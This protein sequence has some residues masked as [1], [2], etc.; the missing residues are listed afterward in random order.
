MRHRAWLCGMLAVT[1]LFGGC[2]E[3]ENQSEH[4][5]QDEVIGTTAIA[6]TI[7]S[8]EIGAEE[9]VGGATVTLNGVYS[10][11][12]EHVRNGYESDIIFFSFTVANHTDAPIAANFMQTCEM[13]IDG[14]ESEAFTIQARSCL[15]QQFGN[16]VESF[17]E[18]IP[19]G[20]T[21]TG[22]I[23]AEMYRGYEEATLLYTPL[24]GASGDNKDRSQLISYTF[25]P[26][27]LEYIGDPVYMVTTST[28]ETTDET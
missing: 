25:H 27:E 16:D 18:E 7:L 21:V 8:G 23:G 20:E 15:Y 9:T 10:S 17:T 13:V 1:M 2:A 3:E 5:V 4:V 6:T 11:S 14:T 28:D 22:Y 19:A 26:D 24:A 12:F